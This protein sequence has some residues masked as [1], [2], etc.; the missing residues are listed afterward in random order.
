MDR[1]SWIGWVG[2][3]E[4]S[5]RRGTR[6]DVGECVGMSEKLMNWVVWG[7]E[8]YFRMSSMRAVQP[9]GGVL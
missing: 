1:G 8:K 3:R 9:R 7:M 6:P 5:M 4:R 2:E